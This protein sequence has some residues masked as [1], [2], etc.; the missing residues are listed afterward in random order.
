M[1]LATES[2]APTEHLPI[3]ADDEMLAEG[4]NPQGPRRASAGM[5]RT[6]WQTT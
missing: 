3:Q 6:G 5:M 4:M 2:R 1:M